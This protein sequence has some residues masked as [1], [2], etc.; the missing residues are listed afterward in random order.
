M[1]LLD[2]ILSSMDKNKRPGLSSADK[3]LQKQHEHMRKTAEKEK[4]IINNYKLKIQNKVA[5]FLKNEKVGTMHFEPMEKVFR[6]VITEAVEEAGSGLLCHTFGRE[7]RYIIVYKNSPSELELEARR[8]HDYKQWNKEIEKE[9]KKK[10]EE[11]AA[12]QEP[13]TGS[14]SITNNTNESTKTAGK[15]QKLIHFECTAISTDPNRYATNIDTQQTCNIYNFNFRNF[16]MVS[17]ELKRDKRTVEQ[18]LN[19]IQEKKRLKTQM[20]PE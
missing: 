20:N 12:L 1:D 8:Y 4:M 7:E 19:D 18:T 10:K 17:S 11:E 3:V 2:D 15:K 14:S 9:F 5:E 13:T 16:G 6:T